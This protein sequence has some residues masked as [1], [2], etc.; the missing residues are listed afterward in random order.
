MEI[1]GKTV[2]VCNCETT[3]TLDGKALAKA[4]GGSG[5]LVV[6]SQLCRAQL[7]NFRDAL[8]AG[9]PLVVACTQESPLFA[10][11]AHAAAPETAVAFTNIRERAG[12]SDEGRDAL[13]KIAALLAE[14]TLDIPSAPSVTLRSAGA[15]LVYGRDET[16]IAAARQLAGRL[17]PT[18]LLTRPAEIVPPRIDDVPIFR[19]TVVAAKGH[20]GAF[21]VVVDDHAP[22]V[23]SSR[24][25]LS[26]EAARDG[27]VSTCDLILD[28]S[29]EAPL[30]PAPEKRDGYFRPDPNNPAAV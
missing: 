30:F 29:G 21:E 12:W 14:A 5:A 18:V 26:F 8:A 16:A 27:A 19:G 3:M 24:G 23:V 28:L 17:D 9:R 15:C 22:L 25:S 1:N 7:D 20:L 13:P 10:E 11:T 2:I 4:C 6:N